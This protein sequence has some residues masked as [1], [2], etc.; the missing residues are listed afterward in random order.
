[1]N[2]QFTWFLRSLS[3]SDTVKT[4]KSINPSVKRQFFTVRKV[5]VGGGKG[6]SNGTMV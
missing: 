5:G 1:M 6:R 4:V 3:V 2:V